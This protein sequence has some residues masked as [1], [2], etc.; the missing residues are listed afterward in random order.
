MPGDTFPK[1]FGF[2]V[3]VHLTKTEISDALLMFCFN[4]CTNLIHD[5]SQYPLL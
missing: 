3:H 2:I 4:T 5:V 1:G